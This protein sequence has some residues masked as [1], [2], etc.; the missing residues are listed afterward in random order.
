MISQ[1]V[2]LLAPAQN[3]RCG[4][5]AI[6]HGA[7]A[8]YIGGPLFGARAAAANSLIDIEQLVAYAHQFRAKVYIAL[9]TLLNDDELDQA[10]ALCHQLYGLGADALI[11]QDVGLLES[12]LPPIPLHSS[13]QMNNRTVEK[14]QFLENVGFTQ[15]VLARELSLAQIKKIRASTSVPLE[16]FVH[17]ALCVAYSGQCYIS[18]VMAGRSAN[19]GECAQFCRH[20]FDLLDN[21]GRMLK[22]GQFLL[23]IKDLD[24]SDHLGALIEAG[25]R[26][27][28]IEGRLKDENYVKNVTAAYRQTLDTIIDAR[29][30]LVRASSG[31]CQFGF[32]PDPS[33]SFSRGKTDYFLNKQ[34][35]VVGEL[36]TPKSIGKQIGRVSKVDAKCFTL[37]GNEVVHNGDGLC[38]FHQQNGLV[39]VKVNRVDG[40]DIYPKDGTAPLNLSAGTEIFRNADTHFNKLL[41]QSELC[42]KI[43]I[44]MTLKELADGLQLYIIDEDGIVSTTN[45]IVE[46]E[47]AEKVG[48]IEP[49]AIKQLNK[50]GGTV[51]SVGDV[52][53]EIS[54][55]L[56]FPSA[57]FNALRR[58]AFAGHLEMRLKSYTAEPHSRSPNEYPWTAA[59]VDYADNITNKKAEEFYRRHGVQQVDSKVL[60]A[61]DAK[62]CALMTTKYCIKAQLGMCP[63]LQN[64]KGKALDEPLTIADNTGNYALGFDCDKCE[65]TV[66]KKH[67]S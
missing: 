53:I 39:G 35:N 66:T 50:S 7:D 48:T 40:R 18:E 16:F 43:V 61:A 24:L 46:K 56:F 10:V 32:T 37:E 27:F 20:K 59:T 51:F 55:E 2:E 23:C 8:V 63:K 14:V 52:S 21:N 38:F 67:T 17:G 15:V 57:V 1:K 6:N 4:I 45:I 30:D 3:F 13:T 11:I 42:R 44:Q 22:K 26:S 36:R 41:E 64:M 12:D 60:R 9:N 54:P 62:D 5:A 58:K 34:R 33:K 49:V 65:M 47:K 19:R 29:N 31:R 25:I 28:K